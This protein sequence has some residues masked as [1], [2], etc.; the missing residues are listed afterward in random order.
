MRPPI[1][2]PPRRPGASRAAVLLFLLTLFAMLASAPGAR[3]QNVIISRPL[4]QPSHI[5][6]PAGTTTITFQVSTPGRQPMQSWVVS[7]TT[8]DGTRADPPINP[9]INSGIAPAVI[10]LR[11]G[12]D[13]AVAGVDYTATSGTLTFD[14]NNPGPLTFTVTVLSDNVAEFNKDIFVG[15]TQYVVD[16]AQPPIR[17][18]GASANFQGTGHP[19]TG[20]AY[21]MTGVCSVTVVD[22]DQPA[23][24]L[25]RAWNLDNNP[26]TIP[27]NNVLPGANNNVNGVALQS[28]GNLI[29]VGDFTAYNTLPA[30]RIARATNDGQFDASFVI[31]QGADNFISALA[32]HTNA[33]ALLDKIVVVGGFTSFNGLSRNRIARLNADGSL[34]GTFD[35]GAGFNGPVRA[36]ALQ[37]DGRVVVGGEFTSFNGV[38]MTNLARLNTNGSLDLTFTPGAGANGAVRAVKIDNAGRVVIGGD[39]TTY[40]A[41]PRNRIARAQTNG[42]LDTL[43]DPGTGCDAPVRALFVDASDRILMAGDFLTFNQF[44]RT[45]IARLSSSG[46]LDLG[47]DPGSG[48]NNTV[49]AITFDAAANRFYIVGAFTSFDGTARKNILRVFTN[50]V[51][52]T[53][54]M[55]TLLNWNSGPTNASSFLTSVAVQES[56]D[57]I[58]GGSFTG[59]GAPFSRL[60]TGTTPAHP[61][62]PILAFIPGNANDNDPNLF[63]NMRWTHAKPRHN[64]ARL[65]GGTTIGPG[66]IQFEQPTYSVSEGGGSATIRIFRTNTVS[67]TQGLA[68]A[69]VKFSTS[70]GSATVGS[71]YTGV[72]N[73]IGFAQLTVR[74]LRLAATDITTVAVPITQDL[75]VEPNETINLTLTTFGLGPSINNINNVNILNSVVDPSGRILTV[76]EYSTFNNT[77]GNIRLAR[78]TS[79]GLLDTG[80]FTTGSGANATVRGVASYPNWTGANGSVR[81]VAIYPAAANIGVNNTVTASAFYS[82]GPQ[83]GKYVIVG[84][85]TTVNGVAWNHVAR[86]NSDGTL[87]T[88]FSPG[89]GAAGGTVN[90]VDVD[91]VSGDVIIGGSFTSFNGSLTSIR[92]ARLAAADG[93]P[94]PAF[95]TALNGGPNNTVQVVKV[96]NQS[97]SLTPNIYVGGDFSTGF[98]YPVTVTARALAGQTTATLTAAGHNLALNDVVTIAN[99]DPAV[100]TQMFNGG[101]FVVTGVAGNNFSYTIPAVDIAIATHAWDL[102]NTRATITTANPHNLVSLSTVNITDTT[103]PAFNVVGATIAVVNATTFTYVKAVGGPAADV[104]QTAAVGTVRVVSIQ[105]TGVVGVGANV[106]LHINRLAKVSSAGVFDHTFNN[107]LGNGFDATVRAIALMGNPT[108]DLFV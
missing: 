49:N 93:T 92:L 79:G 1:E 23:G 59:F 31:G 75:L 16:G 68:P 7:W 78:L 18:N 76:G 12:S 94:R 85:F 46:A 99:V 42:L 98:G 38:N 48:A 11:V 43:F 27:P 51:V 47:F 74:E 83:Q 69:L 21:V 39:F 37:P 96:D 81:A 14:D 102:A 26:N 3:A 95:G 67:A 58:V 108:T 54:F 105:T 25:D 50:G 77:G 13:Y 40:G 28:T 97:G 56:G 34:D 6:E 61:V 57:V 91:E 70:G 73:A 107:T 2:S 72:T 20:G 24:A 86:L 90:A 55:D 84:S 60:V 44:S 89:T 8:L 63:G 87:D 17:N 9:Q 30:N 35:P 101:P 32:I 71:D 80:N 52:D 62:I 45:R 5:Q 65:L 15:V 82:S 64:V 66:N 4:S 10:D 36:V 41:V 33:G 88:S 100:P 22:D 53:T 104:A 19:L 103:D 106:T 29:L